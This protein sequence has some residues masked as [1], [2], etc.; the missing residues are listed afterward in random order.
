[1]RSR[2]LKIFISLILLT[3]TNLIAQD[4]EKDTIQNTL[5]KLFEYSKSKN[6][7]AA[8]AYMIY[9]LNDNSR[10]WKDTFNPENSKELNQVKRM[11]KKIKA[12]LDISD[13]YDIGKVNVKK[14]SEGDWHIVEVSFKSG[15]QTL[16][17]NF[18]FLQ[19]NE[20][21]ALGDID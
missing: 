4:N 21:Y 15:S 3:A 19:S 20:R 1:M 7:T 18:A 16:R 11:C 12:L 14:E 5:L 9:N 6:Y 8:A 10:K 17:T 2:S 13:S